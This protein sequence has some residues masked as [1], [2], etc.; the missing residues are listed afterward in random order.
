LLQ[1]LGSMRRG[2]RD[3]ASADR[4]V[5]TGDQPLPRSCSHARFS[6]APPPGVSDQAVADSRLLPDGST[7]MT[8]RHLR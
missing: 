8:R 6:G 7:E 4:D 1:A 2:K 5:T 3:R